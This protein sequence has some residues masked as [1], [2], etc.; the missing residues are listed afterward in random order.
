M[1][2]QDS[3]K[4]LQSEKEEVNKNYNRIHITCTKRR[5]PK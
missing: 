3:H 4:E 5:S 2:T 1:Y